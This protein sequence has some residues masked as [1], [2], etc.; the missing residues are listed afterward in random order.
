MGGG[1]LQEVVA[2]EGS[3]VLK[4]KNGNC[5]LLDQRRGWGSVTGVSTRNSAHR[6][7]RKTQLQTLMD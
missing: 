4:I 2:H 3:S 5:G 6:R 7:V 1:R